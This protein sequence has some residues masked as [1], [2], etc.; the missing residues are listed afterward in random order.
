MCIHDAN[1]P[2]VF[3]SY[4]LLT[5]VSFVQ[6][7]W[8]FIFTFFSPLLL[9]HWVHGQALRL[10]ALFLVPFHP[11]HGDRHLCLFMTVTLVWV[12]LLSLRDLPS[13]FRMSQGDL[14]WATAA[15]SVL[16]GSALQ[17]VGGL[18]A[19]DPG[20]C[21][22]VLEQD[23]CI[24]RVGLFTLAVGAT[25]CNRFPTVLTNFSVSPLSASITSPQ[26]LGRSS[27]LPRRASGW[28]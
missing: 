5:Y 7:P 1:Q 9:K 20:F 24:I 23:L 12:L 21:Y 14:S 11:Y 18:C 26:K 25:P 19:L 27:Y 16:Q 17:T 15:V 22:Y 2:P 4:F 10:Q 6:F 8:N 13:P 3:P 28:G